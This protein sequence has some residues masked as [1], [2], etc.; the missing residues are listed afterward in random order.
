MSGTVRFVRSCPGG[1][2]GLGKAARRTRPLADRMLPPPLPR[3]VG[4]RFARS[5]GIESGDALVWWMNYPPG[6]ANYPPN[7]ASLAHGGARFPQFIPRIY[8]PDRRARAHAA[9]CHINAKRPASLMFGS[10]PQSTTEGHR[11]GPY[12]RPTVLAKMDQR[13][14]EAR[15]VRETRAELVKHCGGRPSATQRALI[16][17]AAQIR[18]RLA[19]MDRT[20]AESRGTMTAH[21]SRTYLAWSN[22][23]SRLLRQL[24]LQGAP[25]PVLTLASYLAAKAA[26]PAASAAPAAPASPAAPPAPAPTA[27]AA[28]AAA[29]A[30]RAPA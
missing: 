6:M 20:F 18:L 15:L 5:C 2:Y 24:G 26:Q 12:S 17:Q 13:T 9:G 3:T 22:S 27:G 30:D 25:A 28:L 21:D 19:C 7:T 1:I 8:L 4:N 10:P 16:E 11:I 14:R 29:A 23:Y